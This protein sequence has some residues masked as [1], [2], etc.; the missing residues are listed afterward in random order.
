MRFKRIRLCYIMFLYL[1]EVADGRLMKWSGRQTQTN[2]DTTEIS[3]KFWDLF[4]RSCHWFDESSER[5]SHVQLIS[6]KPVARVRIYW[7][8][9]IQLTVEPRITRNKLSQVHLTHLNGINERSL[10]SNYA[11][12]S[13]HDENNGRKIDN[14]AL[15]RKKAKRKLSKVCSTQC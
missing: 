5:S 2:T 14:I 12:N 3:H 4:S 1:N 10:S 8:R 13:R 15:G 6:I 7:S 11:F 9:W